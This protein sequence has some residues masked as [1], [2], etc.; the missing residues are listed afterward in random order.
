[1]LAV[2]PD[3]GRRRR[4]RIGT[5]LA[6]CLAAVLGGAHSL[7]QAARYATNARDEVRAEIGFQRATADASTLGRLLARINGDALDDTVGA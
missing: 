1:M 2:V 4:Y 5:L 6:L 3:P 7:A